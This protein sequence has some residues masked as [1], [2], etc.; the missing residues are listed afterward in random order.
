MLIKILGG[1]FAWFFVVFVGLTVWG[2]LKQ[3]AQIKTD[4][5]WRDWIGDLIYIL[6]LIGGATW[7]VIVLT[8]GHLQ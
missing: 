2:V 1:I 4:E 3:P 5:T 6:L 8:T 7:F